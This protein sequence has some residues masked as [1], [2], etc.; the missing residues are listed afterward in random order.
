[1][2]SLSGVAVGQVPS[3]LFDAPILVDATT[4]EVRVLV[5]FDGDGLKDAV[6][7]SGSGTSATLAGLRSVGDGSFAPSWTLP[8]T[9]TVA[10]GTFLAEAAD[11]NGDGFEDF[12]LADGATARWYFSNGAGTAPSLY[13]APADGGTITAIAIGDLDGDGFDDVATSDGATVTTRLNPPGGPTAWG[14]IVGAAAVRDIVIDDLDGAGGSD[15]GV[16]YPASFHVQSSAVG[17]W[18]SVLIVP[19]VAPVE[20]GSPVADRL[21]VG[22]LDGDGDR[23]A[24]V[25]VV[26]LAHVVIR[27]TGP[28]AWF[29]DAASVAT[30]ASSA[31]IDVD[32]D[33]DLDGASF[34]GGRSTM[35]WFSLSSN[36]G[37]GVFAEA[38]TIEGR[39]ASR[40]L[41]VGDVDGDGRPDLASGDSVWLCR[42]AGAKPPR[43]T[44]GFLP[45]SARYLGDFDGDGDTDLNP[46][47]PAAWS[48][49]PPPRTGD[50][51]GGFTASDV[52]WFT[53]PAFV[54]EAV[55]WPG[56]FD[57]DGDDDQIVRAT[58]GATAS[59]RFLENRG[60]AYFDRDAAAPFDLGALNVVPPQV[61]AGAP[62]NSLGTDV[63]GDGDLDLVLRT[64][65]SQTF[66]TPGL[67]S[68]IRWNVDGAGHF[69]TGVELPQDYI[70]AV[71]DM[72]GD[73]VKDL[74]VVRAFGSTGIGYPGVVLA[75]A[76]GVFAVA[77]PIL[78]E[79]SPASIGTHVTSVADLDG[80]GDSDAAYIYANSLRVALNGGAGA[81]S[82]IQVL[83]ATTTFGGV[84]PSAHA[85]I[86]D[87]DLDGL[88]D[89]VGGPV[90][91]G[92][93]AA[94]LVVRATAPG[95]F[96]P[97]LRQTI[98][99]L[100]LADADGDGDLDA[101]TWYAAAF[102][103][104]H[105]APDAGRRLQFGE[106]S[107]G[108]LG[109]KPILG[110]T[111]PFR[112]GETGTLVVRRVTGGAPGLLC[113]GDEA[114]SQP[115]FGG[116]QFLLPMFDFPFAADGP[117]GVAAD[118][119]WVFPFS[120][121]PGFGGAMFLAQAGVY[122]P[123]ATGQVA[124]TQALRITLGP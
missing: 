80:D 40:W 17:G 96:A 123:A 46:A 110:A 4:A 90:F 75:T 94:C 85:L 8:F 44:G 106:G 2:A 25:C 71:V 60:G 45:S 11:L 69:A 55:G 41:D 65:A 6:A 39:G 111:G 76:P 10:G 43:P 66:G 18:G 119:A 49:S 48:G 3:A 70:H 124:L 64:K 101:F 102:N 103:P 50:G 15:L 63:D 84:S 47:N 104:K 93:T 5:D 9:A 54:Y 122:D 37:A 114:L 118:G 58:T 22:D 20:F 95:V 115:L 99:P 97:A 29:P 23:D 89:V 105:V 67:K 35:S 13:V 121:P 59:S 83:G 87:L 57:G 42:G 68:V 107:A 73:G 91:P 62:W 98:Y 79:S 112:G 7:A 77:T 34:F 86:G 56:D 88:P 109:L 1:M 61:V 92:F 19:Y 82:A 36:D 32:G 100:A 113:L 52:A 38:T 74:V 33:G 16:L 108:A 12:V 53:D 28:A 120:I 117:A 72:N 14:L 78:W 26:N 31:L 21:S 27:R 81:P 116:T 24:L 30:A 51:D